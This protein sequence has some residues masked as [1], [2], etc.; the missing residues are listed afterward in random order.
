MN[1]LPIID[2]DACIGCEVCEQLCPEVFKVD[3][4]THKSKVI[5]PTG[6]TT[7]KI[8]EVMDNCPAACIYWQ[9]A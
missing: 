4:A 1:Q 6:A 7:E 2:Q 9:D 5:N 3:D 8:E